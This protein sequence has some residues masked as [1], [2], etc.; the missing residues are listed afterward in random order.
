MDKS[1]IKQH[2]EML[3]EQ[4][5]NK[6]RELITK[7]KEIHS[8]ELINKQIELKTE[9]AVTKEITPEKKKAYPNPI[10][11]KIELDTRIEN[12]SNYQINDRN[13]IQLKE[14]I[15]EF[16]INIGFMKRTFRAAL[17]LPLL[18]E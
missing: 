3:P 5:A 4:I 10:S 15:E 18:G 13:R 12:N 6:E 1:L 7:Q 11:R 8:L 9:V 2:L 16:E 14:E 17:V